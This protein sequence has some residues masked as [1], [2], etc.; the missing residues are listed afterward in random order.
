VSE[1]FQVEACQLNQGYSLFL[2]RNNKMILF[3]RFFDGAKNDLYVVIDFEKD[4]TL[5]VL[6]ENAEAYSPE[7]P[8]STI[9]ALPKSFFSPTETCILNDHGYIGILIK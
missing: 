7:Q 8:F 1:Q 9:N 2:W 5:M 4:A 3:K 6:L